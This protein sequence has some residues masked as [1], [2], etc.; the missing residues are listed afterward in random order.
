MDPITGN[1]MW[2][3]HLADRSC[4]RALM[5]SLK[6]SPLYENSNNNLAK[7]TP[8]GKKAKQNRTAGRQYKV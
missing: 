5:R 7:I 6:K 2:P 1:K 8:K 4:G 3:T